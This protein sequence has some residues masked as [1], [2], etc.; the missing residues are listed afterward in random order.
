MNRLARS[1]FL[2]LAVVAPTAWVGCDGA[3][4]EPSSVTRI[5]VS[6]T[7]DS[8][9]ALGDSAR[10]NATAWDASEQALPISD[11]VWST[12][13]DDVVTVDA[14][15]VATARGNGTASV[16]ATAANVSGSVRLNVHQKVARVE[17]KP[18]LDTL[19]G[20]G[21]WRPLRAQLTDRN[22]YSIV[23]RR[24]LWH[25]SD[26][27]IVSVDESGIVIAESAGQ[28]RVTA[29]V[30]GASG[31]V[32]LA[33]APTEF[34]ALGA[35]A[36]HSCALTKA[37][38]VLCWG[39][40]RFGQLASGAGGDL[41]RIPEPVKAQTRFKAVS[42]G[43]QHTCGLVEDGHA[44]CWG[45][46]QTGQ[47]GNANFEDFAP[48]PV[49]VA[50]HER[51]RQIVA[52]ERHTCALSLGG[53]AYCWG[54][55]WRGQLGDGTQDPRSTPVAVVGGH[56]FNILDA[57]WAHTCGVTSDGETYCWGDNDFG[58]LGVTD[59]S[60]RFS[61]APELVSG[62]IPF[63]S[64]GTGGAFSCARARDESIYCWGDN[65]HGQLGDGTTD[66]QRTPGAVG[67]PVSPSAAL[68]LGQDHICASGTHGTAHCWGANYYGQLGVGSRENHLTPAEVQGVSGF[69][70]LGA[71]RHHTCGLARNHASASATVYCWGANGSGQLGNGGESDSDLPVR[72]LLP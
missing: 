50:G 42:A 68:G 25:S 69:L 11:F 31:H 9:T 52:G 14:S 12:S 70:V 23:G 15:G 48:Q 16:T 51:Y 4:S 59:R 17:L 62:G 45:W 54:D 33:V 6:V 34:V 20:L 47:L 67:G 2:V 46:N 32:V 5:E 63:I 72:I 56:R 44:L 28:V 1:T 36:L 26:P 37:G 29:S 35:G 57:G 55:N 53:T 41:R 24:P 61:L 13:D 18:A 40:N 21:D 30:D 49:P 71:G 3:L 65:H 8:L 10:L 64:I 7:L 27:D 43:G 22:G 58:Q 19:R 39:D 60:R 66:E 38:I